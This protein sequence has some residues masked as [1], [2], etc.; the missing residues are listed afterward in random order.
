MYLPSPIHFTTRATGRHQGTR[1][2]AYGFAALPRPVE[3]DFETTEDVLGREK[4]AGERSSRQHPG[5]EA[6]ADNGSIC[7]CVPPLAINQLGCTAA[8]AVLEELEYNS[9]WTARHG[10]VVLYIR[11]REVEECFLK[12][13]RRLLAQRKKLGL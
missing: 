1:G 7:Q 3:G 11:G 2:V 4:R 12:A 10:T 6:K 13:T 8:L 9:G 5:P